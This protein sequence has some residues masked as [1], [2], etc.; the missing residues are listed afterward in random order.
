MLEYKTISQEIEMAQLEGLQ[1]LKS[2]T[3]DAW[4]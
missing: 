4:G 3:P 1:G 2:A